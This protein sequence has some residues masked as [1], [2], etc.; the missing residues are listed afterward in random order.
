MSIEKV[1]VDRWLWSVRI[2]KTRTL[3]TD[4]CKRNWVK[5]NDSLAKP[6]KDLFVGDTIS[7]KCGS[8]QR[9]IRVLE[10]LDKRVSAKLVD[11]YLIE[12]TPKEEIQKAKAKRNFLTPIISGVKQSKGRPSKKKRRDLEEFF[13][14]FK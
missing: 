4:A 1:R 11:N 5:I 12:I 9:K 13:S 7:C 3:A 6:S 10:I 8:I 14:Q 2:Y